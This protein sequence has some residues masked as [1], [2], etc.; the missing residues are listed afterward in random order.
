VK[1]EQNGRISLRRLK[2]TVRCNASKRRR[3]HKNKP[4]EGSPGRDLTP[5]TN[6]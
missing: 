5:E 4:T 1:K 6:E 3:R 2:P